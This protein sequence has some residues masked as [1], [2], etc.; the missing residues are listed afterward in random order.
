MMF[1][2]KQKLNYQL[3]SEV[4]LNTHIR[5]LTFT[6]FDT[7]T[8]GFAINGADRMIEIAGV[9]VAGLEVQEQTFQTFVNPEREIPDKITSLTGISGEKVKDAPSSLEALERFF[10]FNEDI[11]SN[12]WVGHYVSFDMMVVKKELLRHKYTYD[13]PLV[14]D[15]LD[16]IGYL[17]PSRD[18][19]DLE[20]YA[21]QFGTLVYERHQALGDAM[22]TAHLFC[23]LMRHLEDRGK[24]TLAD[25]ME[26]GSSTTKGVVF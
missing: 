13:T 2:K 6:I 14:V 10:Q 20:V 3:Q 19:R 8:T 16:L 7:E 5:D 18:M 17:N 9:R 4:P 23:E 24:T 22:T 11:D 25:L 1:W 12:L 15:T 26:I 21:L